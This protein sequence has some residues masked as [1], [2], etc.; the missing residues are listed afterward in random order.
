MMKVLI[1]CCILFYCNFD[2][3]ITT[4]K[5]DLFFY[6]YEFCPHECLCTTCMPDVLGNQNKVW[7]YWIYKLELQ[8]V[9]RNHMSAGN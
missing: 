7:I 1:Y 3:R 8:M 4:L 2:H 9:V 5:L 6:V